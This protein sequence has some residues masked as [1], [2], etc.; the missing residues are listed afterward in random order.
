MRFF[1]LFIVALLAVLLPIRGALAAVAV[2]DDGNVN[3]GT[4]EQV[5]HNHVGHE[6]AGDGSPADMSQDHG[7]GM[8]AKHD[9]VSHVAKCATSCSLTPLATNAPTLVG[10]VAL[11]TMP[12]PA[13]TALV[14]SFI[15]DGQERPPRTF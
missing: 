12:F 4:T 2:C 1:R 6:Q 11:A 15:S 5:L 9:S 8:D 10:S 3:T 14:P 13:Y 7:N